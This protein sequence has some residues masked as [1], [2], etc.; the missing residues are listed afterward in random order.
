MSSL[1]IFIISPSCF[2]SCT[3]TRPAMAALAPAFRNVLVR[4]RGAAPERMDSAHM[5]ALVTARDTPVLVGPGFKAISGGGNHAAAV[6]ADGAL[7]GWGD[8]TLGQL[9][10]G[11]DTRRPVQVGVGYSAVAAGGSEAL[12]WESDASHQG[13]A[14][15]LGENPHEC[16]FC[17]CLHAC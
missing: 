2:I 3:S 15:E 5:R 7:S 12:E 1:R 16:P 6:R 9:G 4:A 13:A 10:L 17:D 11:G 8:N 14:G